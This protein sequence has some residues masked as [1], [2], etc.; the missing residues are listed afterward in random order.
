MSKK[1]AAPAGRVVELF[2][3]VGG[4]RIALEGVP[5]GFREKLHQAAGYDAG[6]G[7]WKVVWGNQWEPSTKTQHAWECYAQRFGVSAEEAVT[8]NADIAT[9]SCDAIPEHDLLVGGFPC[10]DYSVAKPLNQAYG[11]EGRKGVLWW[12]IRRVLEA[13]RPPFVLLE[14]VDRLLKSPAYQRGRDFG[15]IL[16]SLSD[17]G[18]AVE[19][20]VINA[21]EYGFPQRRRRVFIVGRRKDVFETTPTD[22]F[23]VIVRSGVLARAFPA[24]SPNG[25][26]VHEPDDTIEGELHEVSDSFFALFKN[27]GFMIDRRFWTREVAPVFEGTRWRLGDV[28]QPPE[29]VAPG[30]SIDPSRLGDTADPAKGTWR[31]LKGSKSEEREHASGARYRYSEGAMAF[32]DKRTEPSRTILTGEGGSSASRFK[33]AIEQDGVY[34]RLTPVELE[35][36]D[37]FPDGWTAGMSDGRRAFC[38]G[39]ALVV[40]V[41]HRI[42]DVLADEL[43]AYRVRTKAAA[44]K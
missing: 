29:E 9:V 28:L 16:A 8:G 27:A 19:W 33:H 20:R 43:A 24:T 42:G 18:Y 12:Q 37:G 13:K 21:A 40:G 7:R 5:E 41:V 25:V 11:I 23:E 30:F 31:Y 22:G 34:R 17:L 10:Q 3:G 32:P 36:L 14:N 26:A 2:A 44:L 39:N 38:M 4:F 15:I 1:T 6:P 35:R